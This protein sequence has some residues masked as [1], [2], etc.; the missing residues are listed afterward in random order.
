MSH[1]SGCSQ[2][3]EMKSCENLLVQA[4]Q[5]FTMYIFFSNWFLS[6]FFYYYFFILLY[7]CSFHILYF[8]NLSN[9]LRDPIWLLKSPQ[10]SFF[11]LV[12]P[13]FFLK[14]PQMRSFVEKLI[15]IIQDFNDQN[16]NFRLHL[17]TALGFCCCVCNVFVST[18]FR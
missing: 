18:L 3:L 10:F 15:L 9:L 17:C 14:S 16:D 4:R 8:F 12:F 11:F 2:L 7:Y 5:T 6:Y 1:Y 13:K